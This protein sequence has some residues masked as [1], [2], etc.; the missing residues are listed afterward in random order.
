MLMQ[1]A[2][3]IEFVD[4]DSKD[5]AC[6]IVRYDKSTVGLAISLKTN[7]DLAVFMT[8]DDAKQLIEALKTA[9]L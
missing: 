3:T 8:K 7:G 5:D 6:I 4:G 1:H 9:I 2:A